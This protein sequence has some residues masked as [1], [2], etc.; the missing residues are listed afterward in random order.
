MMRYRPCEFIGV[1]V[2]FY[3]NSSRVLCV[4]SL[5]CLIRL[6]AIIAATFSGSRPI[7]FVRLH[8]IRQILR[9]N[10]RSGSIVVVGDAGA[11]S[12]GFGKS[13]LWCHASHFAEIRPI[14]AKGYTPCGDIK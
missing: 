10:D 13:G 11:P 4:T 5:P 3:S 9:L 14:I 1:P 6:Y 2:T 8:P 7:D 12:L